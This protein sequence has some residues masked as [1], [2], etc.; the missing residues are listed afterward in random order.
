L[1]ARQSGE[2]S[3]GRGTVGTVWGGMR[4]HEEQKRATTMAGGW[5]RGFG[6]LRA[7]KLRVREMSR[8]GTGTGT[9]TGI[10]DT[11]ER[12]TGQGRR[13]RGATAGF[14]HLA[15]FPSLQALALARPFSPLTGRSNVPESEKK[16]RPG[17][18]WPARPLFS[19]FIET[20][21]AGAPGC[22]A[23]RT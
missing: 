11:R 23:G 10:A 5:Q 12:S 9:G 18:D 7:C 19:S 13:R 6:W 14:H 8:T 15:H 1:G 17:V 4:C 21:L 16:R 22:Y 20:I 3:E 2:A